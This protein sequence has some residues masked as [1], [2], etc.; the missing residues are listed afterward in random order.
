MLH[1]YTIH[2]TQFN[3]L[4]VKPLPVGVTSLASLS[5]TGTT[6]TTVTINGVIDTTATGKVLTSG[7][8]YYSNS[9]GDLV[10]G[11][12]YAGRGG[13][14]NSEGEELGYIFDEDHNA[15]VTVDSKIGIATSSFN[16]Y[17]KGQV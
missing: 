2:R 9:K 11:A 6:A 3:L 10:K 4:E 12:V 15:Y 17:V 1:L 8:T 16:L 13:S 7:L 5:A 14:E